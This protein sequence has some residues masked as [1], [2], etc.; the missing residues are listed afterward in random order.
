MVDA[1]YNF[2]FEDPTGG[3][4]PINQSFTVTDLDGDPAILS[5]QEASQLQDQINVH[6]QSLSRSPNLH[7][8]I[9]KLFSPQG[10]QGHFSLN[11]GGKTVNV[12]SN[13]PIQATDPA[14]LEAGPSGWSELGAGLDHA[15]EMTGDTLGIYNNGEGIYYAFADMVA[16]NNHYYDTLPTHYRAQVEDALRKEKKESDADL[17]EIKAALALLKSG[18][19]DIKQLMARITDLSSR[20]TKRAMI[21]RKKIAASHI[22]P[23]VHETRAIGRNLAA[24]TSSRSTPGLQRRRQRLQD[25]QAFA[26]ATEQAIRSAAASY[27]AEIESVGRQAQGVVDQILNSITS[28]SRGAL[29]A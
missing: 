15:N 4:D 5:E 19:G 21:F 8:G 12:V 23:A 17:E 14:S 9:T 16:D 29:A 13:A 18:K 26:R 3:F 27:D 7:N 28:A 10:G 20:G 24:A 11:V 6:L 22:S 1:I 25:D 2:T